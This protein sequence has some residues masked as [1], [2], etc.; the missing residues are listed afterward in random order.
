MAP[1]DQGHVGNGEEGT[2][3]PVAFVLSQLAFLL[4]KWKFGR[5]QQSS[6]VPFP[7]WVCPHDDRGT[8]VVDPG[9]PRPVLQPHGQ[10]GGHCGLIPGHFPGWKSW[11]WEWPAG[12]E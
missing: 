11:F 4:S 2:A 9:G 7:L 6:Q 3:G 5:I 1:F 10:S 8:F 12:A